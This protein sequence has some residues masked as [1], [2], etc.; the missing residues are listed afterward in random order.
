MSDARTLMGKAHFTSRSFFRIHGYAVH[1]ANHPDDR[2]RGVAAVIIKSPLDYHLSTTV[3]E[4]H[5]QAIAINLAPSFGRI[6]FCAVYCSPGHRHSWPAEEFRRLFGSVGSRFIIGGDW[7][8]QDSFWGCRRSCPR[9]NNFWTQGG[10]RIF[11]GSM[12][13]FRL[14]LILLCLEVFRAATFPSLSVRA[15]F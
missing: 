15:F 13:I 11:P 3:T 1:C 8:A 5:L 2:N 7:N 10:P 14:P 9:G 6:S 12:I 4:P